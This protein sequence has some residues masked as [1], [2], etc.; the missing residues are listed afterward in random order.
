M[1]SMREM[2]LKFQTS[3]LF[4]LCSMMDYAEPVPAEACLVWLASICLASCFYEMDHV[5]LFLI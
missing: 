5:I 4:L 3:G 1:Y 2:I